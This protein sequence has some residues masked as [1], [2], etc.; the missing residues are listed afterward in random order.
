MLKCFYKPL[1]LL[2]LRMKLF[3]YRTFVVAINSFLL[4]MKLNNRFCA[5]QSIK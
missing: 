2:N 1:V 5:M 3:H 4:F